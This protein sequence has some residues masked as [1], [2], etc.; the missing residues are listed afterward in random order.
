MAM[1]SV[2]NI[3]LVSIVEDV[4]DVREGLATLID[5]AG[6]F[7]CAGL[8]GSAED[9]LRGISSDR[10][11]IILM[12]IGLPGMSGVDG[13]R[14]IKARHPDVRIL[15]LTVYDN[16]DRV[17]DAICAGADGYLLKTTPPP[18]LLEAL[19]DI[20]SGGAPMSPTVSRRVL[21]MFKRSHGKTP[22]EFD[23]SAREHEILHHL[24]EGNSYKMIAGKLSISSHT[25]NFHLKNI[26]RKLHVNSK[27]EA[28]ATVLRHKII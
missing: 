26:Y 8:Y 16:N 10:P 27:S 14:A 7:S 6:D 9:A 13:V 4:Q 5:G 3:T 25:V 18:H 23:L 20:A 22:E 11:D 24:V 21:E 2:P 28:V 17:F 15:M 12:D 1:K 19:R